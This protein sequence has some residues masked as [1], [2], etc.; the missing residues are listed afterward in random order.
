MA[1]HP[2]HLT[3]FHDLGGDPGVV[4]LGLSVIVELD[5]LIGKIFKVTVSVTGGPL[6][7]A[8]LEVKFGTTWVRIPFDH[9]TGIAY[10]VPPAGLSVVIYEDGIYKPRPYPDFLGTFR[11]SAVDAYKAAPVT[12]GAN[13]DDYDRCSHIIEGL[14]GFGLV[15]E[16][17]V[18]G[19]YSMAVNVVPC[20]TNVST[21]HRF[22]YAAYEGSI[23]VKVWKDEAPEWGSLSYPVSGGRPYRLPRT[24]PQEIKHSVISFTD[25]VQPYYGGSVELIG[26]SG[27]THYALVEA[28]FSPLDKYK[29][30]FPPPTKKLPWLLRVNR[31]DNLAL[32]S[33][34]AAGVST[35]VVESTGNVFVGDIFRSEVNDEEIRV[36][37]ITSETEL[38][39]ERGYNNSGG[40]DQTED[41]DFAPIL[42]GANYAA[43]LKYT[44]P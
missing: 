6:Y 23:T 32:T 34:V 39:V 43:I 11:V 35:F 40:H 37:A 3:R 9:D 28:S 42:A 5:D 1:K 16:T 19:V 7:A 33:D 18:D 31:E 20:G 8:Y 38:E 15:P 13:I 12:A 2:R 14:G 10:V 36:T 24:P 25:E 21:K 26:E 30:G 41:T 17:P 27:D 29:N 22:P 4:E 44:L